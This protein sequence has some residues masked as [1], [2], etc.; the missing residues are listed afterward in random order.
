MLGLLLNGKTLLGIGIVIA[1][2]GAAWRIHAHGYAAG[3]AK[4]QAI[5]DAA[6]IEAA[7]ARAEYVER[8]HVASN[9]IARIQAESA[10][11]VADV[12]V[13]TV[14]RV[15]TVTQVIEN[16]PVFAAIPR[17]ADLVRVRNDQTRE[18][19]EAAGRGAELSAS[20][21]RS[22]PGTSP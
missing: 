13:K 15:K 8:L 5:L 11:R 9:E 2:A 19:I 14:V 17:P 20:S 12:E 4:V 1:I 22:L 16:E 3:E 18:L 6:Q 21:I 10:A 7:A